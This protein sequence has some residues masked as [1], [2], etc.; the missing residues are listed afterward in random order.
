MTERLKGADP[1]FEC[2]ITVESDYVAQ[3]NER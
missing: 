1:R 3:D 2:V